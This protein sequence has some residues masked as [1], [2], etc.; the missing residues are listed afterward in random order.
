MW[1][2]V[3]LLTARGDSFAHSK[4]WALF[5]STAAAKVQLTLIWRI[6]TRQ[7]RHHFRMEIGRSPLVS[8]F[9][10]LLTEPVHIKQ[11]KLS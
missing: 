7:I 9:L 11:R 3:S 2:T 6:E 5:D 10:G 8:G 4:N 1:N